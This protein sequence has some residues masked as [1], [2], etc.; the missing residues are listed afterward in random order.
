MEKRQDEKSESERERAGES[1]CYDNAGYASPQWLRKEATINRSSFKHTETG[2]R[3]KESRN[4]RK[5]KGI[6][7]QTSPQY[8]KIG[9][10]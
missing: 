2:N 4:K 8:P 3:R 1:V 9:G 10:E 6:Y 7:E 5:W